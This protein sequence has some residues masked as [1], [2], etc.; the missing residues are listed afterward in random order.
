[1]ASDERITCPLCGFQFHERDARATVCQ[2]CPL[3]GGCGILI[4]CPNCG[5]E[6]PLTKAPAWIGNLLSKLG[7][8]I[9]KGGSR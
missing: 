2:Q 7:S 9:S 3:K 4:K 6:M 1:M 8:W 5:Y